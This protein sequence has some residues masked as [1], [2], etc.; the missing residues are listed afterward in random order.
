MQQIDRRTPL[1][2]CNFN[3]VAMQLYWNHTSARVFSCKF[4]AYFQNTFSEEHLW[5]AAFELTAAFELK[6]FKFY[7]RN[8]VW[9]VLSY[10]FWVLIYT[11]LYSIYMQKQSFRGAL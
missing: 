5:A 10:V 8:V 7:A 4:A 3:K 9:F 11:F 2:K 6:I 1:R